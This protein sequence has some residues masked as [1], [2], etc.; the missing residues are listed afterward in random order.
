MRFISSDKMCEHINIT[1]FFLLTDIF[2][3]RNKNKF[4]SYDKIYFKGIIIG[5]KNLP[6]FLQEWPGASKVLDLSRKRNGPP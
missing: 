3:I 2:Q 5:S 4:Q 6:A 1:I